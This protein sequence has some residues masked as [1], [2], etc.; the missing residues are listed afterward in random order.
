MTQPAITYVKYGQTFT[1]DLQA[2]Q[3]VVPVNSA[4]EI[5][6]STFTPTQ[7]Q[8]HFNNTQLANNLEGFFALLRVHQNDQTF[9]SKL[10]TT[11]NNPNDQTG[12]S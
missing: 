3:F 6:G 8:I 10:I 7:D 5:I 9:I 1:P 2:L 12:L 4:P 11:L